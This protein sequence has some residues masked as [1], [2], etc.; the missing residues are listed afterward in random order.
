MKVDTIVIQGPTYQSPSYG[1]HTSLSSP[2]LLTP[3]AMSFRI[4]GD[5]LFE[6]KKMSPYH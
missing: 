3:S 2:Y 1:M 6:S 4:E 5:R